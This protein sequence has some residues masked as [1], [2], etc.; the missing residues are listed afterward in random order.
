MDFEWDEAKD[1][2]NLAKHGISFADAARVFAG[3]ILT[4]VDERHAYGETRHRAYGTVADRLLSVV[5]TMRG[6]RV[7]II[8]AR[9]AS[10]AERR[11]YRQ[12]QA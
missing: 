8:S 1:R 12:M 3:P 4:E 6:D 10:R 5:Y 2:R 11:T 7:R 9:R